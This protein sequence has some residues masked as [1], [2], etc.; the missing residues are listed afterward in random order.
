MNAFFQCLPDAVAR[1][2]RT[3]A[4]AEFATVSGA[5]VPI[6]TPTFYFPSADLQTLDIGT[7]L[8]YPA[9]AERARRNP[10]V[11][12]LIEGKAE[13][14]VVSIAGFAAVRDADLQANLV[15]YASETIFAPNINP[16]VVPW[17]ATR[18]RKRYY[19]TRMIVC[20]A[21]AHVRWWRSRAATDEPAQ[22]W[23]AGADTVFPASDPAPS[24]K[25]SE[26]PQWPRRT[27][28]ELAD[29][30]LKEQLPAHLTLLDSDG[31]P[32]PMRVREYQSHAEGFR[33]IVPHGAPW[34]EG[35][36]TLSFVGKEIFVGDVVADRG[37]AL[38]RVERVL[39]VL[40]LMQQPTAEI[41]GI[42]TRRME[43]EARRRGQPVPVVP[44][45]PPA[46]TEGARL[47]RAAAQ[48]LAVGAP[49]R[50]ATTS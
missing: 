21:P 46:P 32:V 4:V 22:E 16:D 26:A 27:W 7:G 37:Q 9:K 20:I 23:R 2:I 10:R 42:L 33:L 29:T 13:D 17:Q 34:S 19:L 24:S 45:Q 3:R 6:D 47:R 41:L 31:F 5:G 28:R 40:P 1:L 8:A 15:R 12:L 43:Y 50:H 11:G 30:A 48:E 44:E 38:L 14:P 25:P 35:K 39:P 49:G 36:A 18:E